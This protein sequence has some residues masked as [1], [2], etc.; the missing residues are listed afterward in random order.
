MKISEDAEKLINILSDNG[1]KAYAV[2]G[3]VRDY[4]L[5]KPEKDIDITTSAKPETV[6]EI[7]KQNNI[8][9]IETGLQHGTVT[10]VLNGE[11][12]EITTFR[13]DGEYKDNRR[14]ESVSFVDDVKEDLSRRDFTI[15]AMAYNHK[16]GIV[17]LFGGKKDIDNKVIRAVGNADLRFK[18]D[19][20]RIM[21]ALRFSA[22]LCFDIEEST[23]KAI[24]DNM[25]LLDNIAKERIFTEL[26]RL[27]AGDN[28]SGGIPVDAVHNARA[29]NTVD[30]GQPV[31]AVEQQSIDK[32]PAIM[33]RCGMNHHSFRFVHHDHIA[34]LIEDIQRNILG[35]H[36]RLYRLRQRK[37]HRL[38]CPHAI[39][40][41]NRDTVHQHMLILYQF[42]YKRARQRID[43]HRKT[44]ID[45]FI[46]QLFRYLKAK[47]LH[48]RS[49]VT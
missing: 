27:L 34:V 29:Q 17:D 18:E 2:G 41:P 7:L 20:L 33:P 35:N 31:L 16:E 43:K 32:R 28:A 23:K 21:R 3:C 5:G 45:P 42:L 8:K 14:P 19:A 44:L 49:S 36:I 40:A 22:T 25:Y 6:E 38:I 15:N 39:A 13:K 9:V 26:K 24:F 10:A 1:C 47:T 46:L 48:P 30:P 37:F 12:Y 11:N 4:L